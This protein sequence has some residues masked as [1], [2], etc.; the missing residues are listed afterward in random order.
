MV[1]CPRSND[2]RPHFTNCRL[3]Q[4]RGAAI[5]GEETA[6]KHPIEDAVGQ[7]KMMGLEPVPAGENDSDGTP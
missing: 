2:S 7:V 5:Q 6:R 1:H 4:V 3:H